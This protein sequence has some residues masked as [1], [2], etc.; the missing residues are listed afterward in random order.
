[1]KKSIICCL[2]LLAMLMTMAGCTQTN[3]DNPKLQILC[4][5]FSQYDWARN[6]LG[7]HAEET[8]LILLGNNSADL[9]SYQATIEDLA[10]IS[11]CDLFIYIGGASDTWAAE[12]LKN[13]RNPNRKTLALLEIADIL[14]TE[15]LEDGEEHEHEHSYEE[16]IWLSLKYAV[17]AVK[18]ITALLIEI[19]PSNEADYHAN[20]ERYIAELQVLDGKYQ[21]CVDTAQRKILLFAD[22]F[23]FRYLTEDYDLEYYAAFSGCSA[24]TEAGFSTIAFLAQKV[25]ELALPAV[26]VIET[27]DRI[28]AQTV[29]ANTQSKN[30]EIL[31]LDSIQG[32]GKRRIEKGETYLQIME[33]NL[34]V[35]KKALH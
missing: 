32:N 6:V 34:A 4:T 17:Q 28:I 10:N 23:P 22:R 8:E 18:A 21:Q 30:Q 12:A 5:G 1:M 31:T 35:L 29:I 11:D 19:D 15:H 26:T 3:Y 13:P 27:G 2:L 33:N 7:T 9:H 25:D 24:E 16:H 20:A 14:K